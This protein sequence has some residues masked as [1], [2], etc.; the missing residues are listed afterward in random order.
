[1]PL[2]EPR[3]SQS[4]QKPKDDEQKPNE[5]EQKPN[6]AESKLGTRP[7][8]AKTQQSSQAAR[9]SVMGL[10]SEVVGDGPKQLD[11]KQRGVFQQTL[12]IQGET[13]LTMANLEA[14]RKQLVEN[15]RREDEKRRREDE[16]RRRKYENR[17]LQ[18]ANEDA[19]YQQ[20]QRGAVFVL[21]FTGAIL[22]YLTNTVIPNDVIN[23]DTID[24]EHIILN[25]AFLIHQIKNSLFILFI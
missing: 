24:C 15:R 12:K 2:D 9:S 20:Q 8:L 13:Y 14:M 4:E 7:S 23:F 18:R 3:R 10:S 21:A 17:R 16:K 19:A 22:E 5:V 11:V 1:M 25:I 6:E